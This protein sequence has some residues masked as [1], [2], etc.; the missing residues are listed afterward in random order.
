VSVVF[1][2]VMGVR[3]L[4][5]LLVAAYAALL[6][7]DLERFPAINPDEPG[8]AEPAWT[9]ITRGEFG[10]PMYAGM[11]Q[12]EHRMYTNWPG[13]GVTTVVP[14][15][16]FGP[17][18]FAARSASVVMALMLAALSGV[19]LRRMLE[20]P[21]SGMDWLALAAVLTSPV[22]VVAGRFARPEIDVAA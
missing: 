7:F 2:R 18:L 10:A 5:M 13:R 14:Y 4:P 8:Y 21:L 15:A 16:L 1:M 12:M 6:L 19:A 9:L 11:F 3:V 20:R 17:T 22:V